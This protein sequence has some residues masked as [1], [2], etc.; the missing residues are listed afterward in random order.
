[1]VVFGCKIPPNYFLDE[2]S[3]FE[4]EALIYQYNKAYQDEWE[5]TRWI[6]YVIALSNG[7]KLKKPSDLMKFEWENA[8]D[9]KTITKSKP[10][11]EEYKKLVDSMSQTLINKELGNFIEYNPQ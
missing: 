3:M 9:N 1:M 7:A 2:M 5:Q 4:V 8:I 11:T 10:T 6:G